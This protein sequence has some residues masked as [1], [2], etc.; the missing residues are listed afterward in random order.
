MSL[1]QQIQ[2]DVKTAMK[3]KD[4]QTLDVLRL[5][6]ASIKNKMIEIKKDLDDAEVVAI[7]RSDVKKLTEASKE[8]AAGAREDLVEKTNTEIGILKTYLPQ[9]MSQEELDAKVEAI[10]GEKLADDVKDVGKAM[11]VVMADLKGL[12]DGNRVREAVSKI[13]GNKS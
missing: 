6:S 9:E 8:F 7:I 5:L 12:V 4:L 11:G 3:A 1:Y 2:E 10:L 13:L